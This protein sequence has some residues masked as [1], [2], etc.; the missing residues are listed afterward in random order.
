[1]IKKKIDKSIFKMTSDELQSWLHFRR[2][3]SKIENQKGKGSYKRNQKHK[4]GNI[5][6]D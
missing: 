2:A 3:T 5:Q 6:D 4:G 1:M